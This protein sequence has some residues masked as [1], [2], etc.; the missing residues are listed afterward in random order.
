M[1]KPSV[2]S[3]G[4]FW[5]GGGTNGGGGVGWNHVMVST[6]KV[7]GDNWAVLLRFDDRD[8]PISVGA[9]KFRNCKYWV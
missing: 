9:S 3:L 4:V 7:A 1:E 5:A 2:G 8:N 6:R